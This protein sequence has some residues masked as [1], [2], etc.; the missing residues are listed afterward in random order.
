MKLIKFSELLENKTIYR[1]AKDSGLCPNWLWAQVNKRGFTHTTMR[2][3]KAKFP[4]LDA[5]DLLM[6]Y[7]I[8]T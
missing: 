4:N 7:P 2:T 1:V 3:L 8:E 5:N 6:S